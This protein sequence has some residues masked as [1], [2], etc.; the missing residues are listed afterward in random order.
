MP[1]HGNVESQLAF[2]VRLV[3]VSKL[4]FG[5]LYKHAILRFQKEMNASFQKSRWQ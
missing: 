1:P 2:F 3:I 4:L 5:S